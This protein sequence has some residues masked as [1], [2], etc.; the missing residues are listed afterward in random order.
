MVGCQSLGNRPVAELGT[1]QRR[2]RSK[3]NPIRPEA[4]S[5]F[6]G[7][8]DGLHRVSRQP[9]DEEAEGLDTDLP[10]KAD[11][12]D[13]FLPGDRLAT[14][15]GLNLNFGALDPEVDAIAPRGRHGAEGF[16]IN[17]IRAGLTLPFEFQ[18]TRL[19]LIAN[20]YDP[21]LT[22]RKHGIAKEDVLDAEVLYQ[23]LDFVHDILGTTKTKSQPLP[24]WVRAIVTSERAAP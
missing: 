7:L 23:M 13:D 22:K 17:A 8:E 12:L 4:N 21:A 14:D 15:S 6:D 9:D 24:H 20:L 18:V 3:L 16:F 2:G 5:E 11:H 19:N 10:A 1:D